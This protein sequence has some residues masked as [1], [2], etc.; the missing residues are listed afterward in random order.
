MEDFGVL[1]EAQPFANATYLYLMKAL[2][3]PDCPHY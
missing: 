2:A 1:E 3:R